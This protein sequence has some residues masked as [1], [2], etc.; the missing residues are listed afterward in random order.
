MRSCW[1]LSDKY[2]VMPIIYTLMNVQEQLDQ[3][4]QLTHYVQEQGAPW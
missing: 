3:Y 4:W 1:F 2:K